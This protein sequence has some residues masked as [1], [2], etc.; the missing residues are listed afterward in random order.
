MDLLVIL[1]LFLLTT[2]YM[3]TLDLYPLGSAH[4]R[5]NSAGEYIYFGNLFIATSLLILI[6]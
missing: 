5:P 4:G 1:L 2:S 6:I 3:S